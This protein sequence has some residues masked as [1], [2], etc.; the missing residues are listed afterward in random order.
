MKLCC[1][2][3]TVC[4]YIHIL[5]DIRIYSISSLACTCC[6]FFA[7]K[8]HGKNKEMCL[9]LLSKGASPDTA[10]RRGRTPLYHAVPHLK[11]EFWMIAVV[12]DQTN[13]GT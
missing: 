6:I 8:V 11:V 5:H 1:V 10:D 7:A 3:S 2:C 12:N 4:V 9:W 13:R